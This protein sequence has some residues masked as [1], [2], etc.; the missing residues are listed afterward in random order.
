MRS[1]RPRRRYCPMPRNRYPDPSGGS[2]LRSQNRP[3]FA[4]DPSP[5][6]C[7][8]LVPIRGMCAGSATIRYHEWR[9]VRRW[10]AS[11]VRCATTAPS[12]PAR[13]WPTGTAD[14]SASPHPAR[15]TL[16]QR[17]LES[18]NGRLRDK[19]LN[20]NIFCSLAQARVVITDWKDD[21]NH[22]RG[23]HP[24]GRGIAAR[25]IDAHSVKP[26]DIATLTAAAQATQGHIVVAGNHHPEGGFGSPRDRSP[27]PTCPVRGMPGARS[28]DELFAW[29]GIDHTAIA[30]AAGATVRR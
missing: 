6:I 8:T 22:R 26:I 7:S 9:F 21:H 1:R 2:P 12:S 3:A 30:D 28:G 4:P 23:R 19:C 29:A 10:G 17:L 5:P 27:S 15:R 20:I 14:A 11:Q 13:R 25:V 16:A 24:G 18:F